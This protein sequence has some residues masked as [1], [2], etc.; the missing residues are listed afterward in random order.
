MAIVTP[1]DITDY[2]ALSVLSG[3]HLSAASVMIDGLVGDLEA[4]LGRPTTVRT[5]TESPRLPDPWAGVIKLRNQPVATVNAFTANAV[6]VTGYTVERY[7]LSAVS[8]PFGAASP[9]ALSVAYTAGLTGDDPTDDFGRAVKGPLLR[10]AARSWS[11]VVKDDAA[12]VKS[13]GVE[14]YTTSYGAAL[15]GWTR[16]ELWSLSRWRLRR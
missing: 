3:A 14:G 8:I 2:L 11:K 12:G 4:F 5:F 9:P 7:G 13:L 6:P 1:T 16:D 15:D 10:V